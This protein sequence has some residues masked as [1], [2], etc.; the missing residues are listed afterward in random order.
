MLT[1]SVASAASATPHGSF[2]S[3][4]TSQSDS[5]GLGDRRG[6]DFFDTRGTLSPHLETTLLAWLD[7]TIH[8]IMFAWVQPCYLSPRPSLWLPQEGRSA[9][10]DRPPTGLSSVGT[11]RYQSFTRAQN[12][13][14]RP[15]LCGEFWLSIR[16]KITRVSVHPQRKAL[17]NDSSLTQSGI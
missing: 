17:N 10:V 13:A 11:F 16:T 15:Q 1:T 14:Y 12:C 3:P 6:A 9:S 2:L 7:T 8:G 5:D 4:A